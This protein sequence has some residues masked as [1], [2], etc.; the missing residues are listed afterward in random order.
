MELKSCPLCGGD[1]LERYRL[2]V[3]GF[4]DREGIV[5][6]RSE[7][8]DYFRIECRCGCRFDKHQ[9]ELF[10]KAEEIYTCEG[11]YDA[12]ITDADLW[13]VM[14]AEWNRRTIRID[15]GIHYEICV[16][17]EKNHKIEEGL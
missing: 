4:L 14:I 1:D 12:E 9:D 17:K 5:E 7:I 8:G 16:L 13:N 2:N 3:A 11:K 10:D 15:K 6:T